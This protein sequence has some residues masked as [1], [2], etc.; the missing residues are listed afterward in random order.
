MI[1]FPTIRVE[2]PADWDA[3]DEAIGR[4]GDYNWIVF[5]SANGVEFFLKRLKEKC[6]DL[7]DLKDIRIATIGP[8]TAA[9]LAALGLRVDLIPERYLS[10]GVVE[11]FAGFEMANRRVLL[12]RAEEARDVI[13]EGLR[14]MGALVD[15]AT[16]YR[17]APSDRDPAEVLEP[18]REGAIDVLT[19][20]SPSTLTNFLRLMGKDFT[21]PPNVRIAC[22][23]PITAAAVRKA[24]LPVHIM[25]ERYTV[26][27]L[28]GAIVRHFKGGGGT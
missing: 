20:T 1:F 22:I 17:T 26:E 15:V 28:V 25:E 5:T 8:A 10:E 18:L 3:A 23:G 9:K 2:P 13:P 16:V 14:K 21:L 4:I 6:R 12:P 19:F 27:G 7:R 24:G 11:A